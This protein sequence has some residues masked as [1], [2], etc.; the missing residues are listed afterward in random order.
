VITWDKINGIIDGYFVDVKQNM[1]IINSLNDETLFTYKCSASSHRHEN[2][3][4][5]KFLHS[6][7]ANKYELVVEPQIK[8]LTN[9][10]QLN[11]QLALMCD[12]KEGKKIELFINPILIQFCLKFRPLSFI[13][14][15]I[16]WT[17]PVRANTH[18]NGHI[19]RIDALNENNFG[20]YE[21][22]YTVDAFR[23]ATRIK[24][25]ERLFKESQKRKEDIDIIFSGS[26]QD[27]YLKIL[28]KSGKKKLHLL[29]ILSYFNHPLVNSK[30]RRIILSGENAMAR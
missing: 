7:K 13:Q 26:K 12:T 2:A 23:L 30:I 18:I 4:H 28:C 9:K 5:L 21:C 27:G 10:P 8:L 25:D 24:L 19:V 29:L 3:R 11:S 17:F 16:N 14:D 15:P 6:S 1:L 22:S 20:T